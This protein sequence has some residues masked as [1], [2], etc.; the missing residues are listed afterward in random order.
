MKLFNLKSCCIYIFTAY[1]Y[2]YIY[3]SLV[4]KKV[5]TYIKEIALSELAICATKRDGGKNMLN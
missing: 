1:T 5:K 2:I 4:F 3:A